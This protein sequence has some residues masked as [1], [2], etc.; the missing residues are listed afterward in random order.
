MLK[1]YLCIYIFSVG[2]ESHSMPTWRCGGVD[3]LWESV[4]HFQHVSLGDQ[5][6]V[7]KPGGKAI[8]C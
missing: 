8:K 5:T 1:L 2:N 6:Q 3:N 7:V 4:L